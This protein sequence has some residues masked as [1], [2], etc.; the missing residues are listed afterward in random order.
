M[1][2][3]ELPKL[4][5]ILDQF[6]WNTITSFYNSEK[7]RKSELLSQDK[8]DIMISMSSLLDHYIDSFP[9]DYSN[10]NF[11]EKLADFVIYNMYIT[12]NANSSEYNFSKDEW[13]TNLEEIYEEVIK[14]YF[15]QYYVPRSFKK[16][17][18]RKNPN[19]EKMEQKI[20]YIQN[21]PQP[22]Q[23]TNEWYLF[24]HN[25][26]TAS[27]LWK[28]FKSQ[29][30]I[31]QLICDKCTPV[32]LE[33][34][35][36]VNTESTLHHGHKYEPLSIMYYEHKYNTQVT[37]FGCVPHDN[38]HFIGASPDGINTCKTSKLYGR[39]LE[40]KNI[41]NREITGI[42]KEEYWI[43]MQLQM[44]TCNLNECDF[45]ETKFE[46][47]EN[48][49]EFLQDGTFELTSTRKMK[50]CIIY[51]IKNS[52][53]FYE[54]MPL[55]I[56]KSDYEKWYDET[57]E[58]NSQLTW[59]KNIYWKLEKV[60]CVLVLRNKWWFENALPKIEEV[61]KIIE[62]ERV[63]G[64]SH[65]LPKKKEKK[66]RKIEEK[67]KICLIKLDSIQEE[68]IAINQ[69]KEENTTIDTSN[70]NKEE[71]NDST[72]NAINIEPSSEAK[73]LKKPRSRANSESII[74]N[75]DTSQ[76]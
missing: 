71:S 36:V 52:K 34:Y 20:T 17:F 43:Q 64:H 35:E 59:V 5:N 57:M 1:L 3:N 7:N 9:L 33:K 13:M 18:I 44:E 74:I 10:Y 24:R 42:P 22:E 16:T 37:D 65:R 48:E 68:K 12:C 38:Y 73:I 67:P 49:N 45:L 55:G 21:K 51:F 54:Y 8:D 63:S 28:V 41:V 75:I 14:I 56:N 30:T 46:E 2:F 15:K 27:S 26:L 47:Y 58:K 76:L 53:P 66:E 39:M 4:T 11:D 40:I 60:S 23:Q 61:W 31:N 32:N 50:G 19:V 72:K 6:S 62:S 29:S 69:E 25:I 70:K